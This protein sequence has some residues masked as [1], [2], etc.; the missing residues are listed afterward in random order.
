MADEHATPPF[1]GT[2]NSNEVRFT[3]GVKLIK[4]ESLD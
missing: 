3:Q 4:I 2:P 1:P